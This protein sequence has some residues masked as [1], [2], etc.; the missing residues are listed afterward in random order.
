MSP[1]DEMSN[2][3]RN[4]TR[5]YGGNWFRNVNWFSTNAARQ[6]FLYREQTIE[7]GKYA[8]RHQPKRSR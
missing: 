6:R 5:W 2:P 8:L 7:A 1:H 3:P 4:G